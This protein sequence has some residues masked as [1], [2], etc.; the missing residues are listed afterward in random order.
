[1]RRTYHTRG[2][3]T[4]A[5]FVEIGDAHVS[6][7]ALGVPEAKSRSVTQ[8]LILSN[9]LTLHD[10]SANTLRTH[11]GLSCVNRQRTRLLLRV[12][13]LTWTAEHPVLTLRFTSV[14]CVTS[15]PR[16]PKH[17]TVVA[18]KVVQSLGHLH[19]KAAVKLAS[20]I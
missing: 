7:C 6:R 11:L 13:K 15:P 14:R 19:S 5:D 16:P 8:N 18:V 4:K 12:K 3:P 9:P 1:M 10:P 2:A 17:V 20:A